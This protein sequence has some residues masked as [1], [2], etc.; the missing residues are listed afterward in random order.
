MD[1]RL[2]THFV[3]GFPDYD[4]SLHIARSL[5]AGGAYALEM[6]VPFS[7]PSADGP[8]IEA[9][10]HK[11]LQKGF[12]VSDAFRL[13]AAIRAE[14]TIPLFVM[15]YAGLVTVGGV[16]NFVKQ[17]KQA[18]ADGLIIPDLRPG[19]DEN[20]YAIAAEAHCPAIPVIVPWIDDARL[21]TVLADTHTWIY[22][23]LRSG[24]TGT[25][26]NLGDAQINFLSRLRERASKIA[27]LKGRTA[28]RCM[29]GFGI[30]NGSQARELCKLADAAVVGS[31]V[32]KAVAGA[33]DPGKAAQKL[34]ESLREDSR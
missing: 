18:G 11:A 14:T 8:V 5:I 31:A 27:A 25:Y 15:S 7:D 4:Q 13:L 10:C 9:A 20:L 29:A 34:I 16:S 1:L 12:R 3:A 30:Q 22:V 21:D 28:P 2:I 19:A 6:Q 32:L 17:A 33:E 24:V 23:A 26:T